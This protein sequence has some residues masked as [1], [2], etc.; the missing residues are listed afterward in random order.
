[1]LQ[2]LKTYQKLVLAVVLILGSSYYWIANTKSESD[3]RFDERVVVT[4]TAPV[5]SLVTGIVDGLKHVWYGYFYFVGLRAGND[6]LRDE[7]DRLRGELAAEWETAAENERLREMLAFQKETHGTLLAASV[8]AA[9]SMSFAKS[10][11]IDRGSRHG[12]GRNMA[13]VT[14]SG[15]VGRVV[16]V[17]PFH[18]DVQLLTDGRSAVPVRVQRT[19]AQ[20]V[21]QGLASG[22]C[23]LKY[24]ARADDVEPGDVVITSGLGGIFPRGLIAGTVISVEK[25]EFGVLQ[26]VRVAPAV[27]FRRLP[28]EVFV[29]IEVPAEA[30]PEPEAEPSPAAKLPA[31]PTTVARPAPAGPHDE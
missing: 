11:R 20:G 18:S 9:D 2:F 13:V 23:H 3:R 19:R 1:M 27:D 31:T 6:G 16:E 8:I 30:D 26:E 21:L 12:V 4:L 17:G 29:V 15:V 5:Q 7:N 28:E 14:P 22:I 24:V 25:R 10:L